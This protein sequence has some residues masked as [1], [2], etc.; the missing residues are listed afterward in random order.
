MDTERQRG[1]TLIEL[2]VVLV[3]IGIASAAVSL[4]IQPDPTH[5]MREDAQHLAQVLEAAQSE[6][7]LDGRP[8]YLR[9]DSEGY[10]FFRSGGET[11]ANDPLLRPRQWQTQPLQVRVE[12]TKDL[13]IDAEWIGEPM[14]I[15]LSD[16]QHQVQ[17]SR[18]VSGK[19][20][21]Q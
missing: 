21:I 2:M 1:F 19:V 3:I 7:H 15:L 20:S 16:G 8:I 14:S 9:A 13:L 4:S 6:V 12:P 5:L 18:S 11:F 17:L 10:R